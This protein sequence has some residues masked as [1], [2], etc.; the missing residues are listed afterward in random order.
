M[1]SMG[2]FEG[3]YL[4]DCWRELPAEWYVKA[5][6]RLA[7]KDAPADPTLNRF[8]I[9]SRMSLGEWRARGWTPVHELDRDPR[10]WF[11]WYCRYWLGRRIPE[12]D[13]LQIARWFAFSRHYAQVQK[14]AA[15]RPLERPRQRQ[16]LLQ[17]S[18]PCDD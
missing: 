16:A 14:H 3:K 4:N 11:Q 5:A 9:K 13:V 18:W 1:L 17:W 15:G 2:V 6:G 8:G 10:G 7:K 12:V